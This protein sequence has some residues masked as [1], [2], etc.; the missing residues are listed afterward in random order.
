MELSRG[1]LESRAMQDRDKEE[2]R[3]LLQMIVRNTD[4]MKALVGMQSSYGS[5]PVEE[6]MES[7]QTVSVFETRLSLFVLSFSRN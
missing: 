2:M 3:E 4:N 1:Q 5:N 7:L 6:M